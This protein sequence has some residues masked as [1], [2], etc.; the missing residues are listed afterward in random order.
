MQIL[1]PETPEQLADSLRGAVSHN[2]TIRLGGNFSKDRLGGS[3]QAADVTIS[4]AN[5]NRLLRYDPRDLTV[6]REV[7]RQGSVNEH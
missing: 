5:L 4:T 3:P 2:Q 6:R 1:R 7:V